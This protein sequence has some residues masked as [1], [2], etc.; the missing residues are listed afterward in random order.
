KQRSTSAGGT[1]NMPAPA[2][3]A[4]GPGSGEQQSL[5]VSQTPTGGDSTPNTSW[6]F[7]PDHR[8]GGGTGSTTVGG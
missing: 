4:A 8:A 1:Y 6:I 5:S 7:S 2:G 3:T